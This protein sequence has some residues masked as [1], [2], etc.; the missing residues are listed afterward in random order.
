MSPNLADAALRMNGCFH[1]RAKTFNNYLGF[2]PGAWGRD[3]G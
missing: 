1:H 3:T 2:E